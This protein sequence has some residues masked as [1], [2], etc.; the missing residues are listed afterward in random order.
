VETGEGKFVFLG[1]RADWHKGRAVFS[2]GLENG[3]KSFTFREIVSFPLPAGRAPGVQKQKNLEQLLDHVMLALGVSYWK[4][5]CP[6]RMETTSLA[7]TKEQADF[8]G[9]LYTKGLG[10][11]FYRNKIDFRGL[12]PFP[13]TRGKKTSE[14]VRLAA[15]N[16][17]LLL[18]GGGKDSIVTAEDF[19][20]KRMPFTLFSVNAT[21]LHIRTAKIAQKPLI[22]FCRKIDKKLLALNAK[23]GVYNGHVPVSAIHAFLGVFAA[24]LYGYR[25][26]IA[27][28]EKSANEGNIRW[29]GHIINHQWS[30]SREFE[31]KFRRYAKKFMTPDVEYRSHLSSFSER[32]I[33]RRFSRY[34]KYFEEFSSCNR[35]FTLRGGAKERWCGSCPKCAFVFLA[36]AGFLPK[37]EVIR[38]FE[39][40]LF[41][42]QN[43]IPTY[44]ELL[45]IERH[46]PFECVGTPEESKTALRLILRRGQFDH[47][48]VIR[49][50]RLL[51]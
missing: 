49:R 22:V 2:Y 31:K 3:K 36:L 28:H 21:P 4:T 38:I 16:R 45:G 19:S 43:L 50:L 27:S 25:N 18:W 41:L 6:A 17:S 8:W 39:K 47:D 35:N 51:L 29:R 15:K 40:N 5:F 37:S 32:E 10:E 7:L 13:H 33:A 42:N 20:K 44:K 48:P 11:F 34:P 46:K 23:P 9:T 24:A 30:K 12:T 1:K 14:S 26:V